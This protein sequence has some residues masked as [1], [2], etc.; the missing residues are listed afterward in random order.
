MKTASEKIRTKKMSKDEWPRTAKGRK[1]ED[2]GRLPLHILEPE[3]LADPSYGK[4]SFGKHLFALAT[5][6]KTKSLVD[7]VLAQKLQ[8]GYTFMLQDVNQLDW[9]TD[10]DKILKMAKAPLKHSFDNHVFCSDKWCQS[11]QAKAKGKEHSPTIRYISKSVN[12]DVYN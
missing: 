10:Q 1:K 12:C 8:H 4:K 11:L 7:K 3:F 6:P 5:L 9:L 2:N